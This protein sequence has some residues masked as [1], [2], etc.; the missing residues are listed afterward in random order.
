MSD[1]TQYND[2]ALQQ[3][4]TMICLFVRG[5][6]LLCTYSRGGDILILMSICYEHKDIKSHTRYC[7][8]TL[9][10]SPKLASKHRQRVVRKRGIEEKVW[11]LPPPPCGTLRFDPKRRIYQICETTSCHETEGEALTYQPTVA[12][13]TNI[14]RY[15]SPAGGIYNNR[16][17]KQIH[18]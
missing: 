14:K 8:Q 10:A 6:A 7:I 9:N 18:I 12:T 5:V 3:P 11:L 15:L 13:K 2:S 17:Q 16:N 4:Y 1:A